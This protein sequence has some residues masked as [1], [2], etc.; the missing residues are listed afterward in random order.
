MPSSIGVGSIFSEPGIQDRGI[1]SRFEF[2]N[3]P[4]PH[5]SSGHKRFVCEET[6]QGY[7]ITGLG[8]EKPTMRRNLRSRE[9]KIPPVIASL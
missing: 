7:A 4:K 6:I 2:D 8:D 5:L 1:L 9:Q 3:P